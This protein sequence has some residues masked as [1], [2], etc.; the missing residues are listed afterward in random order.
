MEYCA[1]ILS[2]LLSSFDDSSSAVGKVIGTVMHFCEEAQGMSIAQMKAFSD[3][4]RAKG[5]G[6]GGE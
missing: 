3:V 2:P 4:T 5:E 1:S 6:V